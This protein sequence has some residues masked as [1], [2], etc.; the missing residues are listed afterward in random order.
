MALRIEQWLT[1]G[2]DF[3]VPEV[4]I[5][6]I[7]FD[8]GVEAGTEVTE[9]SEKQKDLCYADLLMWLACS[10][11]AKSSE[12]ISDGGW[13]HSKATKNVTDRAGLRARA[14]QLYKKWDSDKA[15][16]ATA[17]ITFKNLY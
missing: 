15:N 3:N 4:T 6:R 10:S 12:Y 5:A 7:I 14:L 2:V 9:L 17:T 1:G 13:Q 11:S 8:N 16:L